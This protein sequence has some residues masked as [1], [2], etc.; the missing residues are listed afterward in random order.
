MSAVDSAEDEL[1]AAMP[2]LTALHARASKL[3]GFERTLDWETAVNNATS[4]LGS[5]LRGVTS[6]FVRRSQGLLAVE[7]LLRVCATELAAAI[8]SSADQ[9]CIDLASA[10]REL[11]GLQSVVATKLAGLVVGCAQNSAQMMVM[12]REQLLRA[13]QESTE[14]LDA[15]SLLERQMRAAADE[16]AAASAANAARE[17]QLK[18]HLTQLEERRRPTC[19]SGRPDQMGGSCTAVADPTAE[20]SQIEYPKGC[21]ST[22]DRHGM[23]SEGKSLTMHSVSPVRETEPPPASISDEARGASKNVDDQQGGADEAATLLPA[24]GD[25]AEL[26]RTSRIALAAVQQRAAEL[27]APGDLVRPLCSSANHVADGSVQMKPAQHANSTAAPSG[28]R[29]TAV[30]WG[31]SLPVGTPAVL[32]A[33]AVSPPLAGSCLRATSSSA[34][35][36]GTVGSI[37]PHG[38]RRHWSEPPSRGGSGPLASTL[39]GY[40]A[41]SGGGG[42]RNLSLRQMRDLI[43]EV[44]ASKAKHDKRA[45][46]ARQPRETLAVHLTTFLNNKYGLKM[47]IA[48]YAQACFDAIR[49]YEDQD[50]DVA[51]FGCVLRNEVEEGFVEVQRQLKHTVHELLRVYLRGRLPQKSDAHI[52]EILRKKVDGASTLS[53]DEW[54]TIV[55][56]LYVDRDA[57]H[58]ATQIR[59]A[60]RKHRVTNT[61]LC[62]TS[63]ALPPGGSI[64]AMEVAKQQ[65]RMQH[66]QQL[67][68]PYA[69]VLQTL[70][71]FQLNGHLQYLAPFVA[72]FRGFDPRNSGVIDEATFR[73]LAAELV[74]GVDDERMLAMLER[75]DPHSHQRITFSDCVCVLAD[76][77]MPP[78]TICNAEQ[79]DD[80]TDRPNDS[81]AESLPID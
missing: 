40:L 60:C 42:G 33:S 48:E 56:Y 61:V 68:I 43:D 75:V 59:E 7:Q 80:S 58:V 71:D 16:R 15:A 19:L 24:L 64:R 69:S 72:S 13:E 62:R 35:L 66:A 29:P 47:L 2:A 22:S 52:S 10:S 21:S 3:R 70:L 30:A 37:A 49:E 6:E 28:Q 39:P 55:H 73:A 50:A 45:A 14:L 36:V 32:A 67:R 9:S 27:A 46:E 34:D 38:A 17:A 78:P 26:L 74:P 18:T 63:L 81:A 5:R 12:Q 31:A 76:D 8:E 44:Y 51:T 65:L 53:E 11:S 77:V 1:A 4:V 25:T 20:P 23:P 41:C 54:R 57:S 79:G